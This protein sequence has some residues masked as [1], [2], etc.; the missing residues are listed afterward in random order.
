M[1]V[2]QPIVATLY[3]LCLFGLSCYGLH[4]YLM[5]GLY[6]R[7][8]RQRLEPTARWETLP[9]VTVQLPVY[10]EQYVV[11]RLLDA[12]AGLEYPRDRLQIQVLDDSTDETQG[13]ARAKCAALRAEGFYVQYIHRDN[14]AG[15]KAGALQE[16]LQTAT[17]DL[18]AIFDADFVPSPDLLQKTVHYFTDPKVGMV[19]TRWGHLNADYSLLT[20][21]QAVLVDA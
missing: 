9:R 16:G 4:R 20:R 2:F 8:R 6:Y 13:I 17:G 19:Q 14:R 5:V 7:H 21:V 15:F 3:F 1:E 18:V 11:G 10:N 12:V